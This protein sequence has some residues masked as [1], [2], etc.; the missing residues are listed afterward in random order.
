[1][2]VG[3]RPPD[4]KIEDR[5]LDGWLPLDTF[6]DARLRTFIADSFFNINGKRL[7]FT[8]RD[9]DTAV[10]SLTL[11]RRNDA[12][13]TWLDPLPAWDGTNRLDTF[14]FG[15]SPCRRYGAEPGD[16][17]VPATSRRTAHL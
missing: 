4:K 7:K 15:C 3:G 10:Q 17:Q 5:P 11:T 14:V 12:V 9:W 6:V 8:K 2:I 16:G 13:E 1:M